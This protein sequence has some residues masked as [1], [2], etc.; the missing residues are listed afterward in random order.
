M[1]ATLLSIVLWL[2][3][4]VLGIIIIEMVLIRVPLQI[5]KYRYYRK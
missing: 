3:K 5:Y 2:L 4:V 1:I